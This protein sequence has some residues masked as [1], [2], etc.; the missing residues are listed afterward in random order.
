MIKAMPEKILAYMIESPGG[1]RKLASG[2][3]LP[4]KDA[5]ASGIRPR[6]FKVFSVGER[7]DWITE[8]EYVL[9]EHGRWSNGMTVDEED[10]KV[11]LL[12]N[13]GCLATQDTNPLEE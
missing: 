12:D 1:H 4:D 5:E 8:G 2:I 7:I 6:W 10:N 3:L 13:N 11:Y 9:V